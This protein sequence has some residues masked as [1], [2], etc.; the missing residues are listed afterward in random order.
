MCLLFFNARRTKKPRT[1]QLIIS[2]IPTVSIIN[3]IGSV[4]PYPN[5]RTKGTITALLRI[6][7]RNASNPFLRRMRVPTA[8]SKVAMLPKMMSI[9]QQPVKM[10]LS[11]QPMNKPPIAA[12]VKIGSMVRASDNRIWML[13]LANPRALDT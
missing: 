4:S 8:P 9:R 10:L 11:R 2:P 3:G 5:L 7:G 6:G 13:P 1:P 12:G